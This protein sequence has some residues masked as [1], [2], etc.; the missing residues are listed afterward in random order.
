MK[1]VS[2]AIG[3]ALAV[4]FAVT[5]SLG[6]AAAKPAAGKPAPTCAALAFRPVPAGSSDGE[7]TAG[8]YRSRFAR[9]ELRASV[10]NGAPANYYIVAG[11]TRLA[12]AQGLPEAAANCANLKKMTLPQ[13]ATESCMGDRFTIVVAQ[14][15]AKRDAMLYAANGNNWRFCNAGT[16]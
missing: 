4:A 13:A 2:I 12:A 5:A 11:G 8:M 15:G 6:W 9:L 14:A 10:Q 1:I 16:F 3:T 7:Q